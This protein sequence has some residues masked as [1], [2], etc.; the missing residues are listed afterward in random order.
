MVR[1]RLKRLGRKH[2]PFYRIVVTDIRN[3]REGAPLTELGY[4]N[5]ISKQLKLDKVAALAWIGKGAQPSEAVQR[6]INKAPESG[7]LIVL[8]KAQ[9]ERLSR[10]AAE[11]V[12]S[13]EAEKAAA[14]EA[15]KAAEEAAKAEKAAAEEAAKAAPAEEAVAEA[16]AEA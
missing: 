12:K 6:L 5:P 1:I 2:R 14:A 9:K 16:P 4:Y 13:A 8:E 11:K 10:K 15:A 7:E 3:R